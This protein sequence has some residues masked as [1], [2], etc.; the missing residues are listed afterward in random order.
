MRLLVKVQFSQE[1]VELSKQVQYTKLVTHAF[2]LKGNCVI[3]GQKIPFE[4]GQS[5]IA[6]ATMAKSVAS[7]AT[8]LQMDKSSVAQFVQSLE[9][10]QD[11][12]SH[13]STQTVKRIAKGEPTCILTGYQGHAATVFIWKGLFILCDRSG[14]RESLS[15]HRFD[16]SKLNEN[17]IELL[18]NK[19][20]YTEA[21]YNTLINE[22]LP[23]ALAF[24]QTENEKTL[25]QLASLPP[26]IVG[27]CSWAS[28]EG[29]VK[30]FML[31]E[32]LGK[33]S[34]VAPNVP[35]E[36]K[37]L[38]EAVNANFAKW[39][40]YQQMQLLEKCIKHTVDPKLL[41]QSFNALWAIR[42][43]FSQSFDVELQ[44]RLKELETS[45][46][47]NK[48]PADQRRFRVCKALALA[49]PNRKP[50]QH[51]QAVLGTLAFIFSSKKIKNETA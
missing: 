15:I 50:L 44:Q 45:Y 18:I 19:D 2:S 39:Q 27:N 26:Q 30:V 10:A 24:T 11:Q 47:K 13:S 21:E 23:K 34:V 32:K 3:Q 46:K 48:S 51:L 33:K 16:P 14:S 9:Y 31:L 41:I 38:Q 25:Q 28:T 6:A 5:Q 1:L 35:S 12:A 36:Q 4:G 42:T 37:A 8:R 29:V 20:K 40:V 49:L 43:T 22:T 7:F 17:S